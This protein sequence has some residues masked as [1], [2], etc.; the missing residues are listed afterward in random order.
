M[1]CL[2]KIKNCL[3]IT[4]QAENAVGD[5]M[6]ANARIE[7]RDV[8]RDVNVPLKIR[9]KVKYIITFIYKTINLIS[10]HVKLTVSYRLEFND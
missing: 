8:E 4:L 2:W 3:S 10:K 7:M 6:K 1:S 9:R 5:A